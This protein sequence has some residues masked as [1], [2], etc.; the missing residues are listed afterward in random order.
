MEKHDVDL[1]SILNASEKFLR[2][3]E[4]VLAHKGKF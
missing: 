3:W 1:D 4:Y 2:V